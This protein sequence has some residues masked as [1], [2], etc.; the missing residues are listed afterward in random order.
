MA[1]INNVTLKNVTTF[2]GHEG[3]PLKQGN[4]YVGSTKVGFWSQDSWGGCD[5]ISFDSKYDE[6]RFIEKIK[7]LNPKKYLSLE[8]FFFNIVILNN[9]EKIFKKA[10][11]EGFGGIV[12]ATDGYDGYNAIIWKIPVTFTKLDDAEILCKLNAL[13]KA[14]KEFNKE[15][16]FFKHEFFVYRDISDFFVGKEICLADIVR[17]PKK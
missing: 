2:K 1:K 4:I 13:E 5:N 15:N 14:K 17:L 8:D 6:S 7:G 11:K 3:E 10:I 12:V 9:Y 16:N